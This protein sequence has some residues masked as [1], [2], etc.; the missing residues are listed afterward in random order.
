MR[1]LIPARRFACALAV[2]G[3][4][5][6]L[7]AGE[8]G[9]VIV[10]AIGE[11]KPADLRGSDNANRTAE[12]AAAQR[13]AIVVGNSEYQ[14]APDLP[15]A[16]ADAG[17][18]AGFLRAQGFTVIERYDLDRLGFEGLLRQALFEIEQDSEVLFYYAGHGFQ[19]GQRNYLVPV[20]GDLSQPRDV[21]F[22]T[23]TLDSL[24]A[25]L[26]A[27]A[28]LQVVILDSCRNN[29]FADGMAIAGLYSTPMPTEAGFSPMSAP[30]NTLLAFST[31]PG[32]LAL[33][34]DGTNSPYTLALVDA[35]TTQPSEAIRAILDDVRRKVYSATEGRQVP[36]ESSTL[37]E[38]FRFAR[39]RTVAAAEVARLREERRSVTR[40][41]RLTSASLAGTDPEGTLEL[42]ARLERRVALG[43]ALQE[44]LELQPGQ[45]LRLSPAGARGRLARLLPSGELLAYHGESIA[46]GD[47]AKLL[48]EPRH[49][50][51]AARTAPTDHRTTEEFALE[52]GGRAPLRVQLTLTPDECDWQ[53]G[54]HLDPEGTGIARYANE[55]EPDAALAACQRAVASDPENGRFHYQL[56]RA[57]IA[58]K[59]YDAARASLKRAQDL[60]YTRAWYQLGYLTGAAAAI[61]GGRDQVAADEAAYEFYYEGVRRGDPYAFYG[62]G[63]Q[64][65]RYSDNDQL[66]SMGFD[67]LNRA[68][69]VGHTFAMNELGYFFLDENSDHYEPQRGLRY[70]RESAARGDIYGYHNLGLVYERGLGG[71]TPDF[72]TAAEWYRKAALGGHPDAP[73][74]LARLYA[75]GKIGGGPDIALA[76]RWF[77]VA[78]SRGNAVAG[79]DAAWL[80]ATENPE[81]YDLVDAT[82]RAARAASLRNARAK[83]DAMD[84]LTQMP[85]RFVDAAAERLLDELGEEVA[86]DGSFGA[87]DAAALARIAAAE[88]QSVPDK[89]L[90]RLLFL[91]R[92]AWSR[93]KF[94]VDLY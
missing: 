85:Q 38:D 34:G 11:L 69:E 9:A 29:P 93:S 3:A 94:R 40:R 52:I 23:V 13:Y 55:I 72:D 6:G 70:L 44:A 46:A 17:L 12:Y 14:H 37:I 26:G 61:E 53:A 41:L 75:E 45:T 51:V 31:S 82:L 73:V 10:P 21:A 58:L 57:Q 7:G 2:A 77:D 65:L 18:V 54:D 32:A 63:K 84:L 30:V 59:Q 89:P 50:E 39:N 35:A 43:S 60:G 67:L 62:L 25:I 15:N 81:G 24:V 66:R 1:M 71:A 47:L 36:W 5:L 68:L 20:D 91:A 78:L 28:R 92:T 48:Y 76:L 80:I 64:L 19:I 87:D 86:G 33:D 56:A 90:D 83:A 27:R 79:A 16:R 49:E 42:S 4:C 22:E 88:G 74:R 8:A